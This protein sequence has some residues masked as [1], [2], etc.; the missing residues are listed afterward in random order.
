MS[1]LEKPHDAEVLEGETVTLACT[2]T[3]PNATVAWIRNSTAIKAGLK[4]DLK[5]NGAFQ[6]LCIHNLK[7]EDSGSICC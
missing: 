5:K 4:Y 2:I 3:D 6:Q 7:P 1:I